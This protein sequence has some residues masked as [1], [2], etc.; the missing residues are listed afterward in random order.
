MA[1]LLL[2]RR[3]SIVAI[4]LLVAGLFVALPAAGQ[5]D[6]PFGPGGFVPPDEYTYPP[7]YDPSLDHVRLDG[8]GVAY[9]F[10]TQTAYDPAF[11][12]GIVI[13]LN[14]GAATVYGT[15]EPLPP[16]PM[17]LLSFGPDGTPNTSFVDP[18]RGVAAPP[19]RSDSDVEP[20]VEGAQ[21]DAPP[22]LRQPP[23][24]PTD[25]ENDDPVLALYRTGFSGA[26]LDP[27]AIEGLPDGAVDDAFQFLSYEIALLFELNA[28][29]RGT[30]WH[31]TFSAIHAQ[32]EIGAADRQEVLALFQAVD[33]EFARRENIFGQIT[34]PDEFYVNWA[35][36]P[37][38]DQF[39]TDLANGEFAPM[40]GFEHAAAL[41]RLTA[42]GAETDLVATGGTEI[43]TLQTALGRTIVALEIQQ[44]LNSL[45]RAEIDD[46]RAQVAALS[47]PAIELLL[48]TSEDG[49]DGGGEGDFV[50]YTGLAVGGVL[51]ALAGVFAVV[52]SRRRRASDPAR[53]VGAEALATT[54]L[55]AGAKDEADI[56]S[57]LDRAAEQHVRAPLSLFHVTDA[58]V[59]PA[60]GSGIGALADTDLMRIVRTGQ[61]ST[62]LL[63]NDPAFPAGEHAV[64]A[65][66]VISAGSVRAVLAAHRSADE[67]FSRADLAQLEAIAPTLGGT[68][69]RTAELGTMSK[70]A[71][72]DGLTSLGNRRR[73]DGDLETTVAAAVAGDTPLGF[74]MIDVDNFKTY[75]DTHGHS[76]GDDVLRKV[77]ATIASC[78]RDSDVVYRYGGEEFSML[79][80]GATPTDAAAVAERVRAA[81][82]N[83]VFPGED[84]QPGGSL[85][86]SIGV[87]TL[88]SGGPDDVRER[89]DQALYAAKAA[90]RN[91][92]SFA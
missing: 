25:F 86:I 10:E 18:A 9:N 14:T 39:Y 88:D 13:D 29:P 62:T 64:M 33:L 43:V 73:L 67:P 85:T 4:A 2:L 22:T 89:A 79:L 23:A 11:P 61:R 63:E 53:P 50:L 44:D 54:Q 19:V 46:L 58:G 36:N 30:P 77:A 7:E 74:A 31:D 21:T 72:V 52:R 48:D 83:A 90:G 71:M 47:S 78:V 15:G 80:P 1:G 75:N 59:T 60:G 26:D 81:V 92:V 82:E 35:V 24:G 57:I 20:A 87:A 6:E 27:Y 40:V 91:R 65:V 38:P 66:P 5:P 76:A 45:L 55:L 69:A 17:E 37:L 8:F 70:L 49:N 28:F 16:M 3:V 56:L 84:Q 41:A 68:L 34:G 12:P 32:F 51:L 42:T